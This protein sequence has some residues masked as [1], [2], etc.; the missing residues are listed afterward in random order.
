L[1]AMVVNDNA[2]S[3]KPRGGLEFFA[4]I[5]ASTGCSYNRTPEGCQAPLARF[6]LRPSSPIGIGAFYFISKRRRPLLG[7]CVL[8]INSGTRTWNWL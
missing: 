6:K 2:G 7:A 4:S 8:T 5:R 3:L 1:L